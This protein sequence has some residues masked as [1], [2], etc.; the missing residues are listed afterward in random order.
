MTLTNTSTTNGPDLR[1]PVL[2]DT[3]PATMQYVSHTDRL[4]RPASPPPGTR[5]QPV[6]SLYPNPTGSGTVMRLAWP[7]LVIPAATTTTPARTITVASRRVLGGAIG[8]PGRSVPNLAMLAGLATRPPTS[9]T[10]NCRATAVDTNDLDRDGNKTETLCISR[11]A[12]FNVLPTAGLNS[13]KLVKGSCPGSGDY[14][15]SAT[16]YG[17]GP[18]SYRL[19]VSNPGNVSVNN[20]IFYDIFPYVGDRGVIST[21]ARHSEWAPVLTGA[22]VVPSGANVAYSQSTNPCRPELFGGATGANLPAGCTNDWSGTAPTDITAVK[23][24]KVSFGSISIAPEDALRFSWPMRAPVSA[25]IP[26][27]GNNSF[28]YIATRTDGLTPALPA[29]EPNLVQTTIACVEAPP[30]IGDHVWLDANADGIQNAGEAGR[31]GVVVE[32][33]SPGP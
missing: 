19:T 4:R 32:L 12:L 15:A 1:N 21:D 29:A 23:A 31:N 27:A 11:N 18:L 20:A 26:Q 17:N 9:V 28:G 3:L 2:L 5:E 10:T 8:A 24:L 6:L 7:N 16:T 22:V 30:F 14:A 33:L 25:Q 13:V